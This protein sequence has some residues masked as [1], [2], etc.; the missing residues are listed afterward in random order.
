MNASGDLNMFRLRNRRAQ[1]Y[2][3]DPARLRLPLL[4]IVN[5]LAASAYAQTA[6]SGGSGLSADCGTPIVTSDSKAATLDCV[7]ISAKAPEKISGGA[8]GNRS[9]LNTPFSITAVGEQAIESRQAYSV[10]DVFADDASVAEVGSNYNPW[11][12]EVMVRGLFLDQTNSVKINGLPTESFSVNLPLET[13]AQ[14]QLL[15][16]ASGF[17][18]GFAQPGGIINYVTKKPTESTLVSADVG[19]T[20]DQDFSEHV[21]LG[22]RL[23]NDRFGY[24]FN[25]VN[26]AGNT[27]TGSH[28]NRNAVSASLDA[29]LADGLTWTADL[30]YQRSKIL[31]PTPYY[32]AL[33]SAYTSPRLPAAVSGTYNNASDRDLT[34]VKFYSAGTG[35]HWQIDPSWKASLDVGSSET[36]AR[37]SQ[38]YWYLL[39]Q[40]GGMEDFAFDGLDA[41]RFKFAQATVDGLFQ[42]GPISHQVVAGYTWTRLY[43]DFSTPAASLR[44]YYYGYNIYSGPRLVWSP[45]PSDDLALYRNSQIEQKAAFIS[46]TMQF[47]SHWM[48]LAGGRD[49]KYTQVSG[50]TAATNFTTYKKDFVTPTVALMYKPVPESTI[51]A[52]YVEAPQQGALVQQSYANG[53][54]VLDPIV[55]KQYEV[56]VKWDAS[57]WGGSGALFR[58]DEGGAYANSANYYVQ[59]GQLRYQGLDLSGNVHVTHDMMLGLSSVYMFGATYRQTGV[60]WLIG[61]QVP[62]ATRFTATLR[63]QYTVP[64]APG[65]TVFA[66]GKYWGQTVV[67]QLT[68][69]RVTLMSAGFTVMNAGINY[70]IPMDSYLLTFRGEISNVFDRRYWQ[71]GNGLFSAGEPRVLSLKVVAG[72]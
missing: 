35:L 4:V 30:L 63:G 21:D 6:Q 9:Q 7:E 20:S 22:G 60:A 51:Y 70:S 27:Y 19:Y 1:T 54:E 32:T 52:S 13:M 18:Y 56:G 59:D 58:L 43:Q 65:L 66:D 31:R 25:V 3:F 11:S 5:V 49:I 33:V 34:N 14:V 2:R 72:F 55:S 12:S 47:T 39:N 50:T 17:L 41:W 67:S 48:L 68:V 62:G 46:D 61:R 53:G 29:K 10:G 71:A 24:R 15:K 23:S 40:A 37:L 8:L 57:R 44:T 38:E 45:N 36:H 26:E 64:F 16:G 28:I 69:P 42:T